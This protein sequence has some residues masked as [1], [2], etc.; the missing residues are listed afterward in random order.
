MC[1]LFRNNLSVRGDLTELDVALVGMILISGEGVGD[2]HAEIAHGIVTPR[3][4]IRIEFEVVA[5]VEVFVVLDGCG[6]HE[7]V[8]VIAGRLELGELSE[9]EPGIV[10]AVLVRFHGL[11]GRIGASP[12]L[13]VAGMRILPDHVCDT[14][15]RGDAAE[16]CGDTQVDGDPHRDGVVL[17]G[18]EEAV[19]LGKAGAFPESHDGIV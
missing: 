11:A 17:A 6:A 3:E 7:T 13:E 15:Q 10:E 16:P 5:A 4:C 14:R 2:D 12:E 18:G 1:L 8:L 9:A 19:P